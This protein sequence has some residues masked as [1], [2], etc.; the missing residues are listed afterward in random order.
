MNIFFSDDDYKIND[1]GCI[2]FFII[3]FFLLLSIK[4][5]S[6]IDMEYSYNQSNKPE[7][8]Y[9]LEE[10]NRW[11]YLCRNDIL[12]YGIQNMIKPEI[13][14]IITCYNSQE[15]IKTAIR[16]V[17]NQLFADIEILV[18]DDGSID[19]TH[20]IIKKLEKEDKR[21][22]IIKNKY[23]R[24]ALYSKSIGIL[25]AMGKYIMILDSDDLFANENIFEIC[26]REANQYKID[27]IEFSGFNLNK[28]YFK[29]GNTPEVPYYLRFKIDN[30]TVRQPELS[31]FLYQKLEGN[32][33]KLIDGVLWGKCVNST[34]FKKTLNLLCSNIYEK[35]INYGDD[36]IINF[37]LFKTAE[38]FKYIQEYG[39]IYNYNNQSITH[40]N[41]YINNCHDELVNLKS[42]YNIIKST[43]EIDIVSYEVIYR[44]DSILFIGLNPD[45][46]KNLQNLINK[47]LMNKYVCLEHKKKLR[48]ISYNISQIKKHNT[49]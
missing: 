49:S 32:N 19:N 11:I 8:N 45:N 33:F 9:V 26:F 4:Y 41:S 18:V 40:I 37:I 10:I 16:S 2:I 23:N 30:Q 42:I 31:H 20:S 3:C 25:N 44:W 38:S 28:Y 5:T 36:R 15:Y 43:N 39:I 6:K 24:G 1:K 46:S 7:L 48:L 29:I 47:L 12:I 35:K 34:I 14:A 13:T 21:I 22:K 17:Q 27:I